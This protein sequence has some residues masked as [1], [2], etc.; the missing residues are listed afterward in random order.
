MISMKTFMNKPFGMTRRSVLGALGATFAVVATPSWALSASEAEGLVTKMI[1]DINKD[2]L[3]ASST[4]RGAAAFER[5]FL[6]YADVTAI[7]RYVLGASGR[8]VSKG[9][10]NKFSDAYIGYL[11]RKYSRRFGDFSGSDIKVVSSGKVKSF[12]KVDAEARL[13]SG[14]KV[15]VE[16]LVSDKSG[17]TRVFNI[18][19][20]GVN[21]LLTERTEV[22]ALLEARGGSIAQLTKDLPSL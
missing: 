11:S 20:E 13:A 3:G 14:S 16:L 19:V 8:G 9:D 7:S 22:G 10:L 1:A 17:R 2:V 15:N 12:I 4:A 18:F 21:L 5:V 6:K